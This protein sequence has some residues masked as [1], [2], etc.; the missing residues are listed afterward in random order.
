MT[1]LRRSRASIRF[2]M[3]YG[4]DEATSGSRDNV[5]YGNGFAVF[6]GSERGEGSKIRAASGLYFK[7]APPQPQ[8]L[9]PLRICEKV[10][11]APDRPRENSPLP[12]KVVAFKAP[13]RCVIRAERGPNDHH[14][15]CGKSAPDRATHGSRGGPSSCPSGHDQNSSLARA[16]HRPEAPR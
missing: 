1:D 2:F 7:N 12:V 6:K 8:S 15:A 9:L 10:I 11:T 5:H 14:R 16:G 4:I 3:C 13:T